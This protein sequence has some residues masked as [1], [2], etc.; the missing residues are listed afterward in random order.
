MG[1]GLGMR[2]GG[3]RSCAPC[4]ARGRAPNTDFARRP[5]EILVW[6]EWEWESEW[7]W[8]REVGGVGGRAALASSELRARGRSGLNHHLVPEGPRNAER[9]TRCA[10][11]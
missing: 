3:W 10:A 1:E 4:R 8:E 6:E 2:G 9:R 7:E 11:K 5:Q